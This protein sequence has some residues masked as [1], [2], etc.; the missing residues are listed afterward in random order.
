[1][2]K[3]VTPLSATQVKNSKPA[4]KVQK[5]ADGGGLYLKIKPTGSKSWVFEYSRPYTKRRTSLS[6]GT[7]PAISL[8]EARI[9][10]GESQSLLAKKIDPKVYRD[11][12]L[13][14]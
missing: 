4:S 11:D 2:P 6:F 5:I 14:H 8:S 9:L 3:T 7:Y 12:S 10:R 13:P 1:M